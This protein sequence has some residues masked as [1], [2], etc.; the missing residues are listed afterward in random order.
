M[1]FSLEPKK[2]KAAEFSFSCG[3]WH[4]MLN[5]GVGKAIGYT[6]GPEPGQYTQKA[7]ADGGDFGC[8]DGARVTATEATH[9]AIIAEKI[10]SDGRGNYL[11]QKE[12]L[13]HIERFAKWAKESGGFRVF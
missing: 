11:I 10:V 9:M 6:A 1:S 4:Q 2:K 3:G 7:R 13:D 12:L 5:A 8:N